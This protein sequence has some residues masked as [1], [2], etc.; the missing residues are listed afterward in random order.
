[1]SLADAVKAHLGIELDKTEQVGDWAAS[2]LSRAQI[3]YAAIDAVMAFRLAECILPVLGP[4]TAPTNS[5]WLHAR[6]RA[7]A[8][9]GVHLD[10]TAHAQLMDALRAQRVEVCA[11]YQQAC[12][13]RGL[14]E[15]AAKKPTT[16]ALKRAALDAISNQQPVAALA[17]RPRKSDCYRRRTAT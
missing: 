4:Q 1:M 17:A 7:D 14:I 10:L 15:L 16:P 8:I 6:G 2:D 3:E 11:A 9:R 12:I 13:D 5:G